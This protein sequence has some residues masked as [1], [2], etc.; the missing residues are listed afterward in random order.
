[1]ELSALEC[2]KIPHRLIMGK[3]VSAH[4]LGCGA[5]LLILAGNEDIYKNLI[6]FQFRPDPTI[7][8]GV[9]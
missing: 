2:L 5:I 4:F 6:E 7:D 9:I 8:Y 3:M 1:M